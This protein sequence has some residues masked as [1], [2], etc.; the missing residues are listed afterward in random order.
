MTSLNEVTEGKWIIDTDPGTDDAFAILLALNSIKN[1]LIAISVVEGNVEIEKCYINAKKVCVINALHHI[2]I[3]KGC[4]LNLVNEKYTAEE[5]HGKDG[6]F[7]IEKFRNYES[8]YNEDI[9]S[10]H[11]NEKYPIIE[12]CSALK[13][14]ELCYKH[15]NINILTLGPLTNLALA[16]MIDPN[17][18]NRIG[19]LVIMGGSYMARGNIKPHCEF[20]FCVN[21]IATKIVLD[22][23]KNIIVYPW[24][25]AERHQL[26]LEYMQE[27]W[28]DN[29]KSYFCREIIIKKAEIE[30]GIFADY[31][32]AVAALFP[33]SIKTLKTAYYEVIID[34]NDSLNGA[35]VIK[36][37]NNN[38]NDKAKTIQIV[39]ELHENYFL[40]LFKYMIK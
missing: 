25:T 18:I 13:I 38:F 34:S 40:E 1:N 11:K 39:E 35:L 22:N 24:E 17:I 15:E 14:I 2:P 5:F 29:E 30:G 37:K 8:K 10:L 16:F 36:G 31:G 26:S 3:Y 23:F 9:L 4:Y 27:H 19:K 6:L 32:A 12:E 21:P 7:D 20:N 28:T 33:Q